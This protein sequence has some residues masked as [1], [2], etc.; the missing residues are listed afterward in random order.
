[1]NWTRKDKVKDNVSQSI[2]RKLFKPPKETTNDQAIMHSSDS[3]NDL[4]HLKK[5][6]FKVLRDNHERTRN[7]LDCLFNATHAQLE[8]EQ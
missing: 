7:E 6:I 8:A 4:S 1:M 3:D 2:K 5:K